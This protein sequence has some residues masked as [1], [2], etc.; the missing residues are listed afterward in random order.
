MDKA[1][2]DWILSKYPAIDEGSL[3]RGTIYRIVEDAYDA[4]YDDGYA[5]GYNDI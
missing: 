1:V 3:D 5:D 2:W 4:G